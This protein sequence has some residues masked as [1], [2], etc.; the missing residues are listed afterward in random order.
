MREMKEV[1]CALDAR[2]RFTELASILAVG[3][4]RLRARQAEYRMSWARE[5]SPKQ[6]LI[7]HPQPS[8]HGWSP[9]A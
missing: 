3:V 6:D 5:N 2:A 8:V 4:M 1:G 7:S 9:E